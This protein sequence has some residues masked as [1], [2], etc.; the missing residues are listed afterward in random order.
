MGKFQTARQY[1]DSNVIFPVVLLFSYTLSFTD[2]VGESIL[3]PFMRLW[4]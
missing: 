1:I 3:M 2:D 4:P